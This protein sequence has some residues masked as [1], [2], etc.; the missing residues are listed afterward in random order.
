[1]LLGL[2]DDVIFS[3]FAQCNYDRRGDRI[4]M[5]QRPLC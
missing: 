5:M 2:D 4:Q 3:I 1:M